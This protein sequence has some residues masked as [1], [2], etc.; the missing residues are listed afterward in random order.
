MRH[1]H[2]VDLA[3]CPLRYRGF[4]VGAPF[5]GPVF[6]RNTIATENPPREVCEPF[7]DRLA[8]D[9]FYTVA[10]IPEADLP[11]LNSLVE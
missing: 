7:T 2:Q 6:I 8:E 9:I 3:A 5:E 1:Q 4:T 10:E 11:E